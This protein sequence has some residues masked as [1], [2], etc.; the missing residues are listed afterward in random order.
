[1][2][3]REIGVGERGKEEA[4]ARKSLLVGASCSLLDLA[5]SDVFECFFVQETC[6]QGFAVPKS[7]EACR[8]INMRFVP[9]L[10]VYSHSLSSKTFTILGFLDMK[11]VGFESHR[12][13]QT[14]V[15]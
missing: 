8:E 2:E 14:T 3:E 10:G 1:M 13:W 4:P 5:K 15:S 12:H 7:Q 6:T 11:Q 9:V